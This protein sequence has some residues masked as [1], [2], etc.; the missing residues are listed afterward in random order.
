MYK[1]HVS[2]RIYT[3]VCVSGVVLPLYVSTD[4]N[5]ALVCAMAWH[6]TNGSVET[7]R[8]CMHVLP[9]HQRN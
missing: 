3:L 9:Q 4:N 5:L 1:I 2:M 7:H 8:A 6:A